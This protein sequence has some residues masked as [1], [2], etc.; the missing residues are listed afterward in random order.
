M[1]Y[2]RSTNHSCLTRQFNLRISDCNNCYTILSGQYIT[3][4]PHMSLLS[5]WSPVIETSWIVMSTSTYTIITQISFLVD[6][7]TM[8]SRAESRYLYSQLCFR[9]FLHF[10]EHDQPNHFPITISLKHTDSALS[11]GLGYS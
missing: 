3:K 5:I 7:K 1:N 2:N 11:I 6:V 4:I 8:L 9:P 10:L